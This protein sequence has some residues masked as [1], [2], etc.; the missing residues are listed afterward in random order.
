[1]L[2]L[3]V[4][5]Y[6]NVKRFCILS[7]RIAV[8]LI[9]TYNG[10][11]HLGLIPVV[12]R[13]IHFMRKFRAIALLTVLLLVIVTGCKTVSTTI[14]NTESKLFYGGSQLETTVRELMVDGGK[15]TARIRF[16]NLGTEELDS[17]EALVQFI[18]QT[19]PSSRRTSSARCS[20]PLFPSVRVSVRRRNAK[21][22]PI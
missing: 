20:R 6:Q 8:A 5:N 16:L 13:G 12:E 9:K 2:R 18:D 3:R 11:D 10:L 22:T 19:A 1:M 17:I 14:L 7:N 21:A 15:T 4:S